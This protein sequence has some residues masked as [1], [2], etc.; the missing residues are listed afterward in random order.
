MFFPGRQIAGQTI[1]HGLVAVT[2]LDQVQA[3]VFHAN[4]SEQSKRI[5]VSITVG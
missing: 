1:I 5:A 4:R 2:H 3:F